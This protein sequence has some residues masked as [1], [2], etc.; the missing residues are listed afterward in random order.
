MFSI[1][2]K[3]QTPPDPC[4]LFLW[5]LCFLVCLF[6]VILDIC[7]MY[8]VAP[9]PVTLFPQYIVFHFLRLHSLPL[10]LPYCLTWVLLSPF[11]P[12][13]FRPLVYILVFCS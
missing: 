9:S 4:C 6:F 13:I 8:G 1:S 2:G 7:P 5:I 11:V 12:K 3:L 10:A